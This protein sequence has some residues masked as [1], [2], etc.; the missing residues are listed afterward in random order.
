[1]KKYLAGIGAALLLLSGCT[2]QTDVETVTD[3]Y[4]QPPQQPQQILLELPQYS[5][6][7]V[8]EAGE[9]DKM[10]LCDGYTVCVQ[11]LEGGNLDRTLRQ[12]T[13]YGRQ[14]LQLQRIGDRYQCVWSAA[15]EEQTQVGRSCIIDDG[16]YHYAL[17][18]MA[19][20]AQAGA[21]REEI[22]SIFQS[23]GVRTERISTGS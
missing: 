14:Q 9:T 16:A 4:A 1:M 7:P 3:V 20:E 23:F 5:Y 12:V 15:G 21:L 6:V 8:M 2:A 11:T 17:T 22:Q 19:P 10:Y 18:V 13:G